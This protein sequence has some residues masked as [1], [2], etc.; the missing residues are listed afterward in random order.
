MFL[1]TTVPQFLLHTLLRWLSL[2]AVSFVFGSASKFI[3][4]IL[5]VVPLALLALLLAFFLSFAKPTHNNL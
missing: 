1:L 2:F 4:C 3:R 5:D